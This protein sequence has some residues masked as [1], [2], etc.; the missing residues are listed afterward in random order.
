LKTLPLRTKDLRP[1]N[2]EKSRFPRANCESPAN[3]KILRDRE[4]NLSEIGGLNMASRIKKITGYEGG[5]EAALSGLGTF[6]LAASI[7]GLVA[8]VGMAG[9]STDHGW[10]ESWGQDGISPMW[11]VLGIVSLIQGIAGNIFCQAFAEV[12]R[13]LKKLTDLPY[14]GQ[15]SQASPM[16]HYVCSDC[17]APV[18]LDEEIAKKCAKCDKVFESEATIDSTGPD[19]S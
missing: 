3:F 4:K 7:L 12:I 19:A 9:F 10:Q 14:G 16:A 2:H 11:I 17:G 6:C 18:W 5:R 1:G 15:I 8:A 13:L